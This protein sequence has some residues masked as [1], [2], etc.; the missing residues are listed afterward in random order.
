MYIYVA[1]FFGADIIVWGVL[2]WTPPYLLAVPGISVAHSA[3]LIAIP[4]VV[5]GTDTI[6]GGK[7]SD[8][9]NGR[10]RRVAAPALGIAAVAV[11]LMA[12]AASVTVWALSLPYFTIFAVGLSYLSW[13]PILVGSALGTS[14]RGTASII[15]P[16]HYS[17]RRCT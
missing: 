10:A 7:L 4:M 5:A 2:I 14:N 3:I 6:L 15:Q 16:Y 13:A 9:L 17:L 11:L 12:T 1:M 8:R